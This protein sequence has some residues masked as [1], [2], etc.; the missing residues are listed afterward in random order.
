MQIHILII[1]MFLLN[2]PRKTFKVM[3]Q[4]AKNLQLVKLLIVTER[5]LP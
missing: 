4:A 2:Q 3:G 1:E 5:F